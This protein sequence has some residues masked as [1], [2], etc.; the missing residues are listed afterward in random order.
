MTSST[1]A[2][3]VH[4]PRQAPAARLRSVRKRFGYRDVLRGID[5]DLERGACLAVAGPNGAGKSTLLRI[6][7]TQ[8]TATAGEVE[9]LGIDARRD[10]LAVRSRVGVCAHE[11]FLRRELSF[12]EN[13]RFAGD[14]F[15]LRGKP[16]EERI[17]RLSDTFGLA[18]RRKDRVAIFS[19]GMLRRA[20][21]ARSLLHEPELWILDEPFSGLDAHG[22]EILQEAIRGFHTKGGTVVLVTHEA[23]LADALATSTL[24]VEGGLLVRGSVGDAAPAGEGYGEP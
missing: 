7:S 17:G 12:E 2:H 8:W 14:L 24:R 18:H 6:L 20:S 9:V 5:L 10:P 22:R 4:G 23:A 21:L 19:Q 11:S 1:G 13:L 16:L 3:A 15:G